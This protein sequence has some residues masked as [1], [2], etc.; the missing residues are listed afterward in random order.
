MIDFLYPAPLIDHNVMLEPINDAKI[1]YSIETKD[2]LR[3][4]VP[5]IIILRSKY[6]IHEI[7]LCGQKLIKKPKK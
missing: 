6:V 2:P 1:L 7:M 4:Q 5:K 3:V